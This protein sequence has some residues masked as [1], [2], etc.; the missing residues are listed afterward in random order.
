MNVTLITTDGPFPYL[1]QLA[2]SVLDTGIVACL[3]KRNSQFKIFDFTTAPNQKLIVRK[4]LVGFGDARDGTVLY[5]PQLGISVPAG[6]VLAI[7]EATFLRL[8]K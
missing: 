2:T 7:E 5:A 3:T 8:E 4:R 1:G 6:K